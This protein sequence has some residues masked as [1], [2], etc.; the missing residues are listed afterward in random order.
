M[1]RLQDD[2]FEAVNADWLTHTDIPSDRPRIA[3]FDE[4]VIHN[5]QTL[6]HDFATIATFDEPVMTEFAKFYKKAGDFIER[7]EFGTDPVRPEIDKI[8]KLSD[9]A[10]LVASLPELILIVPSRFPGQSMT[11]SRRCKIL[12]GRY[13]NE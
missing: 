1:V 2:L 10:A 5:E 12:H 3:A 6:M 9:Y 13:L 11:R 8:E 4:L 7:F